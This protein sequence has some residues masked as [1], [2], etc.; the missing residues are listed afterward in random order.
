MSAKISEL[1]KTT[2]KSRMLPH[3]VAKTPDASSVQSHSD[4]AAANDRG[5]LLH[6]GWGKFRLV[7][8]TPPCARIVK[9]DKHLAE[10]KTT[11][12]GLIFALTN[13]IL[14]TLSHSS[15]PTAV[16]TILFLKP[17]KRMYQGNSRLPRN[18][19]TAT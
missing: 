11:I 17:L 14:K 9:I 4:K 3:G 13:R 7:S 19:M 6:F 1:G 12:A 5:V 18:F 15:H 2:L 10:I 16:K 8:N